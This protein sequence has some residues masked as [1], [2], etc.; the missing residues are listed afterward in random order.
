M[1]LGRIPRG[2]GSAATH[3]LFDSLYET[4]AR[5]TQPLTCT[6][7]PVRSVGFSTPSARCHRP[8]YCFALCCTYIYVHRTLSYSCCSACYAKASRD[9]THARSTIGAHQKKNTSTF[10]YGAHNER[11]E[12]KRKKNIRR[13]KRNPAITGKREGRGAFGECRTPKEMRRKVR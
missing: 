6:D 11:N 10:R 4:G 3:T 9:G 2:G 13:R 7:R 8:F 1:T 12:T 5:Q